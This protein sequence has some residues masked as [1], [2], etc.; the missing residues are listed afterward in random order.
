MKTKNLL[1]RITIAL[2]SLLI[3]AA[4]G[5]EAAVEG[6]KGVAAADDAPAAVLPLETFMTNINDP[7]G[8]RHARVQVKLAIV[9]EEAV[10][11]IQSDAV[12]MARIHD[13][14]LTLL[15]TKT[16]IELNDSKGKEDFRNE[17]RDQ[18]NPLLTKGKVK[19]VLFSD[20]V[21]E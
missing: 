19:E 18:L 20:F 11:E 1:P 16:A 17:V 3:A 7:S 6:Q 15:T 2:L 12:L 9:P 21:V 4:C 10:P 13:R 5:E 8:E 14:V